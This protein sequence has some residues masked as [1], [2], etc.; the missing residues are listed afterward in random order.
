M[1][2]WQL[3]QNAS[4]QRRRKVA[5]RREGAWGR[6]EKNVLKVKWKKENG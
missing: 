1:K 3:T 6:E 4:E 5:R 2:H